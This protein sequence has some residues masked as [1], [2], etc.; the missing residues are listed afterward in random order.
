MSNS[1]LVH[2][3]TAFIVD[4]DPSYRRLTEI[5]CARASIATLAFDTAGEFLAALEKDTKGC[6]IVDL[7]M[8]EMNALTLHRELQERQ[9]PVPTILSTGGT[10]ARTC[11][12]GFKSGVFDL[13]RKDLGGPAFISIVKRALCLSQERLDH[14]K[15]VET[16]N[17][18]RERLTAKELQVAERLQSGD[19]LVEI[20]RNLGITV[21]TISK[22]RSSIFEKL[23]VETSVQIYQLF[24]CLNAHA[25]SGQ[26]SR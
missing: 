22:H 10:N 26:E 9:I 19:S 25:L 8:L 14:L 3:G 6:L 24:S 16:T 5:R 4:D 12:E 20:G 17:Q 11:R 1:H 21:Q 13:V 23:D 18:K 7:D 2:K 15:L